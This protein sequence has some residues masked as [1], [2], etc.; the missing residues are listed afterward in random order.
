MPGQYD[1]LG[2]EAFTYPKSLSLDVPLVTPGKTS[3]LLGITPG[4]LQ[5]WRSTRRYKLPYVKVGGKVMYR[6]SAI[7]QFIDEQTISFTGE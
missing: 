7:N 6:L 1:R 3:K 4:T 2:N 5:V